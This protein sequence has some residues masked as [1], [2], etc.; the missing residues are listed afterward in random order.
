MRQET[1]CQCGWVGYPRH[2]DAH[3]RVEH[4]VGDPPPKRPGFRAALDHCKRSAGH[5]LTFRT[6]DAPECVAYWDAAGR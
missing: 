5:G 6:C 2:L 1:R 3:I 4:H